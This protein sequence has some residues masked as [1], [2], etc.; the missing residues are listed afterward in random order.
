MTHSVTLQMMERTQRF[1]GLGRQS[2]HLK[3]GGDEKTHT[4][5]DITI[6][7]CIL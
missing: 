1:N 5:R 6:I 7:Y 2:I 4:E 3:G